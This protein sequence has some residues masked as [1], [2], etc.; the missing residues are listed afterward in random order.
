M[1]FLDQHIFPHMEINWTQEAGVLMRHSGAC[2]CVSVPERSTELNLWMKMILC[3]WSLNTSSQAFILKI[4]NNTT[5][6][7]TVT[8]SQPELSEQSLG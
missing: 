5:T 3:S 8:A 7:S 1:I 2:S 4:L 6:T